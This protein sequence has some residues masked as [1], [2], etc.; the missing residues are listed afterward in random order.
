VPIVESS[1]HIDQQISP[2]IPVTENHNIWLNLNK[3][4]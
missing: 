4:S 3:N 1:I 2:S